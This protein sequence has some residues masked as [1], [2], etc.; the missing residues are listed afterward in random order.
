MSYFTNETLKSTAQGILRDFETSGASWEG[1][2]LEIARLQLKIKA[3]RD[4]CYSRHIQADSHAQ[5]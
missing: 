1:V 5:R 4:G 3:V 2:A